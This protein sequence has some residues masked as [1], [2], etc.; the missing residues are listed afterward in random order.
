MTLYGVQQP[1][2][3]QTSISLEQLGTVIAFVLDQEKVEELDMKFKIFTV[4]S[5][6][7][8]LRHPQPLLVWILRS[9]RHVSSPNLL[10][11]SGYYCYY[12]D[13]NFN[14]LTT[15][16]SG[17]FEQGASQVYESLP[18]ATYTGAK[19]RQKIIYEG[20]VANCSLDISKGTG[21]CVAQ[22]ERLASSHTS[23][24]TTTYTGSIIPL[25]T[26]TTSNGFQMAARNSVV[27]VGSAVLAGV[28]AGAAL[29]FV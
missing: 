16:T 6:I 4:S 12:N 8:T 21:V 23:I 17:T 3:I 24:V 9:L 29:I 19:P 15:Q 26:I 22:K 25:A 28:L 1:T 27:V 2:T 13:W 14:W 7:M 20:V 18:P 10:V 11:H 5:Y